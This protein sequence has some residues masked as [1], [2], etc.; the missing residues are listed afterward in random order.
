MIYTMNLLDSNAVKKLNHIFDNAD[1]KEGLMMKN[2]VSD[3]KNNLEIDR[4]DRYA[5]EAVAII[6]N[7]ISK[8]E[9]LREY[10]AMR[11]Y[12]AVLFSQYNKD[13]YYNIHNDFPVQSGLRTDY[14]CTVFLSNPSDYEGGELMINIGDREIPYKLNP[15]EIVF[16]PSGLTH[17]VNTVKSGVRRVCV[18]W[19]E[20]A[21][22]NT[23]L[24]NMNTELYTIF[25][26][27]VTPE[28][29][30]RKNNDLY[31]RLLNV[32]FDI[33]RHFGQYGDQKQ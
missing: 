31:R 20:S 33:T 8:C 24:R 21:I 29:W 15:G 6:S 13:M 5:T 2:Y 1:F 30:V 9:D 26:D 17:R 32:K 23:I 3:I 27:Y 22:Q 14:S 25:K 28:D 7:A 10:T 12:G 18:F 19:I 11:K 16:Y 4:K